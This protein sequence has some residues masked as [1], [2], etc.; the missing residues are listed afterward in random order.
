[1]WES[2]V[3]W[4]TCGPTWSRCT[5]WRCWGQR[6]WRM[7]RWCRTSSSSRSSPPGASAHPRPSSKGINP[8]SGAVRGVLTKWRLL[9][10][11][12][13]LPSFP[14]TIFILRSK[15]ISREREKRYP[16]RLYDKGVWDN[17]SVL[18]MLSSYF[19]F[20]YN[21]MKLKRCHGILSHFVSIYYFGPISILFSGQKDCS[22]VKV[23]SPTKKSFF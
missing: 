20:A 17:C 1:M 8:L 19:G 7:S 21:F 13:L 14:V 9:S 15:T 3:R 10:R 6:R 5:S 18:S 16:V 11:R 23:L 4:G 2:W 22:G 12:M